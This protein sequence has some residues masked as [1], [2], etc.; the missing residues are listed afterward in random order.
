MPNERAINW[1]R[2]TFANDTITFSEN[3]KK[4][5]HIQTL[6]FVEYN[7]LNLLTEYYCGEG[8][9]ATGPTGYGIR[10]TSRVTDIAE[11]YESAI[12]DDSIPS[13]PEK[14]RRMI[15]LDDTAE[16]EHR[17]KNFYFR[18]VLDKL[19]NPEFVD[20]R[21]LFHR[22]DEEYRNGTDYAA[23]LK[24]IYK[25]YEDFELI[26]ELKNAV[27]KASD[28]PVKKYVWNPR[29]KKMV[30]VPPSNEE[31]TE[32]DLVRE[33]SESESTKEADA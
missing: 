31:E 9:V 22:L 4:V 2:E 24:R 20:Y 17:K 27:E 12:L 32:S 28:E 18:Y 30:L 14:L 1:V 6:P 33:G 23:G 10:G 29:I 25:D 7:A 5:E 13:I 3:G 19:T 8:N 16:D 26:I 21:T 11:I 15:E